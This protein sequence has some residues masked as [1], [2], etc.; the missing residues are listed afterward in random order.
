VLIS[1]FTFA[2]RLALLNLDTL[3]LARL[4]F[5]LIFYYKGFNHPHCYSNILQSADY[6]PR[7]DQPSMICVVRRLSFQKP[8]HVSHE[9]PTTSYFTDALKRGTIFCRIYVI[10]NHCAPLA[11][12]LRNVDLSRFLEGSR[13]VKSAF[14]GCRVS[15]VVHPLPPHPPQYMHSYFICLTSLQLFLFMC[16]YCYDC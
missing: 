14:S 8:A 3:E 4:R 6:I 1:K 7:V 15:G 2:Q 16:M 13:S 12:S 9:T 5:D 10:L 11:Y